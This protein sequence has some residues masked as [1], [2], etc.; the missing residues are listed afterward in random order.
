MS[1]AG[2]IIDDCGGTTV[3]ADWFEVELP[4]VSNWRER[5]IPAKRWPG[6]IDLAKVRKVRGVTLDRL[7][8]T[9]SAEART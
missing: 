8:A 6:F 5:G 4:V 7:A 2:T 1:D 9:H 3:V